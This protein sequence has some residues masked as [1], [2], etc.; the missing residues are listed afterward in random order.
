MSK[1]LFRIVK[2]IILV[3]LLLI[4]FAGTIYANLFSLAQSLYDEAIGLKSI[5]QNKELMLELFEQAGSIYIRLI[6]E[7]G[8]QNAY[9]YYNLANCY[10]HRAQIGNAIYYYRIAHQL[11]PG[12]INI[13]KNLE[14]ARNLVESYVEDKTHD[15]FLKVL[16]FWHFQL[17]PGIRLWIGIISF[18]IL[19]MIALINLVLRKKFIRTVIV[20]L[21]II[22]SVFILSIVVQYFSEQNQWWGVVVDIDGIEAKKGP[23]NNY[24]SSFEQK[25]SNGIEFI[26]LEQ[27]GEWL[28]I[29]LKNN[30][31]CW[32]TNSSVK[33]LDKSLTFIDF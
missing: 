31:I 2:I 27:K 23:G 3:F 9:L 5:G 16:F 10:Y 1:K 21:A 8:F 30:E 18:T 11:H 24:E 28:K 14:E 25:L 26:I 20:V 22:S 4:L 32:L 29:K 17:H 15:S 12:F 33:T 6:N 13:D 19:W 7:K